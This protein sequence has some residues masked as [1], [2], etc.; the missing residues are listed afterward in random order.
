[1]VDTLFGYTRRKGLAERSQ[2]KKDFISA[3]AA[4]SI[5]GIQ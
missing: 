4:K 1:V 2:A 5:I 3:E